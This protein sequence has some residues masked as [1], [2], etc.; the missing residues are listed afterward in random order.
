MLDKNDLKYWFTKIKASG[1]PTPKT[2][3]VEAPADLIDILDGDAKVTTYDLFHRHLASAMIEIGLP[4]FLRTGHTSNKHSWRD[5][6]FVEDISI[7]DHHVMW[8]TEFSALADIAGL[9][10]STW[11]VRELLPTEPAFHA[12][13]GELPITKERRYFINN[14]KITHKQPYWPPEAIK[15]PST[16]IWRPLLDELNRETKE[17]AEELERLTLQVAKHFHG[18]WSVDWLWT[19]RGWV[20]ID[21]AQGKRSFRWEPG[22]EW[23]WNHA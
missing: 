15:H 8:L 16:D 20:L 5:S 21:M 22:P 7:L 18:Y 17:E 12:F 11:A 23:R 1:V 13:L 3:I 2:I 9:P 10:V 4:C 14:G 19:K 6:C